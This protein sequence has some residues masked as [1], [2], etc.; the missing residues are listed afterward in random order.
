MQLA[1]AGCRE[2]QEPEVGLRRSFL[3]ACAACPLLPSAAS[4]CL[5]TPLA[6]SSPTAATRGARAGP[7]QFFPSQRRGPRG[8]QQE[9]DGE[10]AAQAD[11]GLGEPLDGEDHRR[12]VVPPPEDDRGRDGRAQRAAGPYM[13]LRRR[14]LVKTTQ[15]RRA[16]SLTSMR[17]WETKE[18]RTP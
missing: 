4:L 10:G 12:A 16:S 11:V 9:L 8:L 14:K 1:I 15:G 2:R 18:P 3:E 6:G 5:L 13:R 17:L 7:G